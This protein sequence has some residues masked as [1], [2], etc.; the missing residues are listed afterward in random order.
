VQSIKLERCKTSLGLVLRLLPLKLHL[1]LLLRLAVLL[2][3]LL[4]LRI[5][6]F[7]CTLF[8]TSVMRMCL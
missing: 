6:L 2:L 4:L 5:P 7:V 8:P 1:L 3:L